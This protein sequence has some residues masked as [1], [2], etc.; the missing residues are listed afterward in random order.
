MKNLI[1]ATRLIVAG[2]AF[3][4]L[5]I[6]SVHANVPVTNAHQCGIEFEH[7][8]NTCPTKRCEGNDWKVCENQFLQCLNTADVICTK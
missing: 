1:K 3:T 7:C 5:S 2:A 6:T 4:M 8:T